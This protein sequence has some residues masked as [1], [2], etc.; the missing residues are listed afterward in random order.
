MSDS[1]DMELNFK[2]KIYPEH[3][4]WKTIEKKV[5]A[6]FRELRA[7]RVYTSTD[8]T[9]SGGDGELEIRE[10]IDMDAEEG[11]YDGYAY[12]NGFDK[13]EG[14]A[15]A[16]LVINF[17]TYVDADTFKHDPEALEAISKKVVDALKA[18]GLKPSDPEGMESLVVTL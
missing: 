2:G 8:I 16:E 3:T 7:Q 14:R 5:D 18:Q 6:A 1:D 10:N 4:D 13:K 15:F 17:G 9:G 11:T 12:Y